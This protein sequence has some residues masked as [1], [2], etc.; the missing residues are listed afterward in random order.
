M[1]RGTLLACALATVSI[2]AGCGGSSS[3]SPSTSAG[4]S[5]ATSNASG[6]IAAGSAAASSQHSVAF[7]LKLGL[8]LHG[9]LQGAGPSAAL[10]SGPLSLTFQGHSATNTGAGATK[11]DLHFAFNFSGGSASGE[12]LSPDGRTGY[13]TLPTVLGP[14]WHSFPLHSTGTSSSTGSLSPNTLSQL[15]LS[16]WLQNVKLSSS[17][18]TDTIAADL[19]VRALLTDVE[20]AAN[21]SKP[22]S[23]ATAEKAVSA[24]HVAHGSIS[25]DRSS[26]LPSAFNARL[27]VVV[28]ADARSTARGI[29]GADVTLDAQFADWGKDFT[30]KAPSGATPLSG[31]TGLLGL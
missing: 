7:N 25:Y 2:A 4:N 11:F 28:P 9:S 21:S 13:L 17:G 22:L 26:H 31:G 6:V 14:G 29:T 8:T 12:L 3:S 27:S 19:N 20:H 1:N 18:S 15:H 10:L 5:S 16:T 30:V 24:I 23:A